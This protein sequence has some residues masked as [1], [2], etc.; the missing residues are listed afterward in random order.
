MKI[1]HITIKAWTATFRL[2]LSY[3]GAGLTSPLPP[4]STLLGLIGAVAGREIKF[5]ETGI[6]YIFRSSG[7]AFDLE[8]T[9]RLF[10]NNGKLKYQK[11]TSIF[12]RQFHIN[13]NLNLYLDN[14]SFK[15]YFEYPANSPCLGRS[16]D[17]AWITNVEEIEAEEVR[18]GNIKGTL[19]PFPVPNAVGLILNLPDYFDNSEFG[20][21]RGTGKLRTYQAIRYETPANIERKN[22]YKIE[23]TDTDE[24]IYLHSL[25]I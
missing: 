18:G 10:M 14:L 13:P 16:Q 9:H 8:T 15:K 20:Y 24:V 22:L 19:V 2:P 23:K 1:L 6:G 5:D 3:S 4:Y 7:T 11:D 21:T 25:N 12:K 17:L